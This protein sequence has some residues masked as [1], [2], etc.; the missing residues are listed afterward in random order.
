MTT[1]IVPLSDI[2]IDDVAVAGGKGANLGELVRAG[3]PVP[4]GFVITGRCLPRGARRGGR[5][6]SRAR[7][8]RRSDGGD[9]RR[10]RRGAAGARRQGAGARRPARGAGRRVPRHGRRRRRRGPLLGHGGG[11]RGH[12]VRRHERDLHERARRG[13]AARRR[14]STAGCPCSATG[15]CPTA[16]PRASSLEPAL[17]VVVQQMVDA[18]R[19]GVMFT[20]DP[21]T[22]DLSR[23][24]I[25]GAFGLGEVVVG[26]E[27]EPDTYVV[28]RERAA[29]GV[30]TRGPQGLRD[31]ARAR[32]PRPARRPARG[33]GV[34]TGAR[35]RRDPRAR[36]HR[37]AGARALR[38][39]RRTSSGR[40]SGGAVVHPA[41]PA[42]HD[43]RPRPRAGAGVRR[44]RT[45][46]VLL[47][48][49][50]AS[51]GMV[52]GAVRIL[53]SPKDGARLKDG[54]VLVAV[55]TSPDWVPIIKRASALVT[56]GGGMTCHA[57]IVAREIGVPCVVGTREA[58]TVLHDDQVVT[59]DATGGRVLAGD[60]VPVA[61]RRRPSTAPRAAP[62]GAR[63]A[64]HA[65]LRQPGHGRARR[66]GGRPA[67]RRRG[68]AARGVHDHRRPRRDAPARAARA[69]RPPGVHRLDVGVAAADHHAPSRRGRSSTAASTSG[70]TSSAGWSGA[71]GSSRRRRTR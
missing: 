28:D 56:D 49:Q 23:I 6:R 47:T 7:R 25:E 66:A 46:T 39:S 59:V 29:A 53:A 22:G 27:V 70:P 42:H 26:G 55:M 24:V 57:A 2:G 3:L 62:A 68:P 5:A 37:P 36:P 33:G 9:R 69:R 58:T 64:R 71:S 12:V 61:D 13:R 8:V 67:R 4:P 18:D 20:A 15:W 63:G 38:R 17:A 65:R 21:S 31:R 30:R 50:S 48:G 44:P 35:R 16:A 54:D 14:C 32:R 11:Q 34:A 43:P 41:V 52:S 1:W 45:P 60:V 51:P 40:P 10:V 19:S